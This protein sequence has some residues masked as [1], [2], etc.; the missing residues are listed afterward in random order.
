MQE[1]NQLQLIYRE[2][3]MGIDLAKCRQCGCMRDALDGLTEPLQTTVSPEAQTLLQSVQ[4]WADLLR[5][6]KYSCL[7]CEHC[8]PAVAQ[9]AFYAAFPDLEPEPLLCS[10]QTRAT[11]WPVVVGEYLTL[12]Q[13][14]PVAVSTLASI[15]LAE[16]LANRK[17]K[18]LSIVGKTETEN[19]GIDKVVKNIVS[20]PAIE[21]L[22]LA[23]KDPLGHLSGRTLLALAQ[24]GVDANGRVLGSPAKRPILRNVSASEIEAFRRQVEVVDLIGCENAEEIAARVEALWPREP[25]PSG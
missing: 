18:G 2:L 15:G 11:G 9:N 22:V 6:V 20:N 21:Y 4:A 19:I 10:L 8:Y 13:G 24:N 17:P 25:A 12:D 14:A 1:N 7:G 23:G 5:P 16:E 3:E